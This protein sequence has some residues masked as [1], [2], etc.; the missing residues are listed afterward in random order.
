MENSFRFL[1]LSVFFR[2]S[3]H[4][5]ATQFAGIISLLSPLGVTRDSAVQIPNWFYAHK[6]EITPAKF[7][8]PD[9][10]SWTI[11]LSL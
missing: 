7:A 5:R 9:T 11:T 8:M 6:T 4:H 3:I 1:T 10:I 2:I